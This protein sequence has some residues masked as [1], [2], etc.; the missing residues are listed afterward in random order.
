MMRSFLFG[1]ASGAALL[2]LLRPRN[3]AG[4]QPASADDSDAEADRQ[5]LVG[6]VAHELRTPTS[7]IIGYQELLSEGLLGP[8]DERA[9]EALDRI[10]RAA[11]QLRDLTDGLEILTGGEDPRR[12]TSTAI[13]DLGEIA[14]D[15]IDAA[16]GDAFARGLRVECRTDGAAPVRANAEPLGRLLDLILA[17]ALRTPAA[18]HHITLTL[19][20]QNGSIHVIAEGADFDVTRDGASLDSQPETVTSSV[21][22]RLAIAQRLAAAMGGR[23]SIRDR[24]LRLTLPIVAA[25]AAVE[26]NV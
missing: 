22:L 4:N 9:H 12:D 24:L 26:A 10:R 2:S 1:F 23:I 13:S 21:G 3:P 6:I 7:I 25:V 19:Q 17:A 14:R 5:R 20:R 11:A 8:V 18:P 15:V 16:S